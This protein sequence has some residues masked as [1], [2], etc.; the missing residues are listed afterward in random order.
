MTYWVE[1][2]AKSAVSVCKCFLGDRFNQEKWVASCDTARDT[3]CGVYV[4]DQ[5]YAKNNL[6]LTEYEGLSLKH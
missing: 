6:D 1:Y 2:V 5:I 4:V 3:H